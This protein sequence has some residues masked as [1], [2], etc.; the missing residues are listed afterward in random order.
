VSGKK[1][2]VILNFVSEDAG[3]D[4]NIVKEKGF[5]FHVF[6]KGEKLYFK[7]NEKYP[8]ADLFLVKNFKKIN[9]LKF[10]EKKPEELRKILEKGHANYYR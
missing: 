5:P 8:R 3:H 7:K 2:C 6:Y 1:D 10:A 4:Y 9:A